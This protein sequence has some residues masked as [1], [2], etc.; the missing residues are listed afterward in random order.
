MRTTFKISKD[1][2]LWHNAIG[3]VD[4]GAT[5]SQ[6]PEFYCQK[7]GLT[8]IRQTN[9]ITAEGAKHVVPLYSLYFK[10]PPI[11]LLSI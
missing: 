10:C 7:I 9:V 4:T 5:Y 1:G 6:I 11:Q 2:K 3:M 8:P